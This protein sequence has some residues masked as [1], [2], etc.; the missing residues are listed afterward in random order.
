MYITQRAFVALFYTMITPPVSTT[1][2]FSESLPSLRE[3]HKRR[4]HRFYRLNRTYSCE[5]QKHRNTN[6]HKRSE[7][8]AAYLMKKYG[9][10]QGPTM[11]S[12]DQVS[13]L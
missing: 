6:K 13:V 2:I 1:C 9:R 7:F 8:D 11:Q 3:K 10:E 4:D 12:I 5:A